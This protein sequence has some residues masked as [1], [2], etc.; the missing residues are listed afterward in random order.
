MNTKLLMSV[1]AI[2]QGAVGVLLSFLPQET[3]AYFHLEPLPLLVLLLQILG[4]LYLG[5]AILNWV[6]KANLIGGIYSRPIAFGNFLHFAVAALAL[7]KG[8][9]Y[10]ALPRPIVAAAVVYSVFAILF[11]YVLFG[12]PL[13]KQNS[14]VA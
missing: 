11:G 1:V 3:A 13:R 10:A 7:L 12:H 9:R 4:A 6:A 2:L 5:F 8:W 14:A